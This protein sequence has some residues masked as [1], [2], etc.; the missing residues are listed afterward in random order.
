[1]AEEF[2]IRTA[3]TNDMKNVFELSNDDTVRQNSIHTEK[4]KWEDHVKWYSQAIINP[5]IKF[6]IIEDNNKNFIGQI[7]FAKEQ[8]SWITSISLCTAYRGQGIAAIALIKALK[9]LKQSPVIALIKPTNIASFKSFSTAGFKL[10]SEKT[11]NNIS[12]KVLKYEQ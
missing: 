2:I 12:Y 5:D 9:K 10:Y 1:M 6:Y 4:I 7:R 11:I 8:N 3:E